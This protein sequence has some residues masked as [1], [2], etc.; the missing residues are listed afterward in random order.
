M[1]FKILLLVA[2][3]II[4]AALVVLH[5][6]QKITKKSM[7]IGVGTVL[8][9]A[10]I[11]AVVFTVF[12][13]TTVTVK[14]DKELTLNVFETYTEAGYK[15]SNGLQ[16]VSEKVTV[17]GDVDVTKVGEYK[18]EYV[19]KKGNKEYKAYRTIKVVDT[20]APVIT[21]TGEK[22]VTVSKIELFKDAGFSATDNYNGDITAN[23]KTTTNKIS[24]T[25]YEVIYTATDT[26]G[27]SATAKRDVEIKDVVPPVINLKSYK[28]LYVIEN[29]AYSEPGYTATDDADGDIT[30]NVK[31]TGSVNTA[32]RG[33][34]NITYTVSDKWGNTATLTR[35]VVV[36]SK[37]DAAFNR[38]CLTFDDG[39]SND[40]TVQILN[41]LKANDVKATFFSC[42]YDASQIPILKRMINE[43]H[44]IG[45]HG[46]SHDYAKIYK[47][48]DAFME[49]INKL[50]DK[51]YNDTGY[52]TTLMRFPGGGSNT[53]SK[54]PNGANNKG[55]M[56]RL[57]KRVQQEG[58]QYF[59]WNVSSGDA[60]PGGATA[61]EIYRNVTNGLGRK[62]TNIVLMHDISSKK[63][64]AASLKRI[65]DYAKQAG[66]SFAAIDKDTPG[67]HHPVNN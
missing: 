4:A 1:L 9:L 37:D 30:A 29:N 65:I 13:E 26:S 38:I 25:K 5:I 23:V 58:W 35:Q 59:D 2:A 54:S 32:V 47:T 56:T 51:L 40:V 49:N 12:M 10:V 43:G 62:R 55:A 41:T 15:A 18:I 17:N 28:T 24:D 61:D 53:V 46:Y 39:P 63:T 52:Y 33:T 21:L 22:A 16:D 3:I 60:E 67:C 36:C 34:Y 11:V 20:V 57:T 48:D 7:L 42:N 66:Y 19:Y 8:S 27:N 6:K 14:G 31:V 44:A 64:T 50:R 45:I